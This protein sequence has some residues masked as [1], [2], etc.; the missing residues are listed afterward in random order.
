M[1]RAATHADI[2]RMIDI[3]RVLHDSSPHFGKCAYSD[4]KVGAVIGLLIDAENGLAILAEHDGEIVG[5]MLATC[6]E[7]W[8]SDDLIA[9]DLSVFILPEKRGSLDAA[10][11][12]R[13][14][15]NW[16]KEKG[17]RYALAGISTGIHTDQTEKLYQALGMEY[18]GP[19]LGWNLED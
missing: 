7:Q 11:M 18:V 2:P 19:V 3:G 9:T 14:Y 16:A 12:L 5:G 4:A 1:I 13:H 17:C 8:Y 6:V 10:R 15:R